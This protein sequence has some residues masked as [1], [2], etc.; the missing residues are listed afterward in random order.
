[1]L[2]TAFP[3]LEKLTL[4][5]KDILDD[6]FFPVPNASP[7]FM[8]TFFPISFYLAAICFCLHSFFFVDSAVLE[9]RARLPCYLPV[10]FPDIIGC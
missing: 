9:S 7:S 5:L 8:H 6:F 4:L 3:G 10:A 2:Q 1:M